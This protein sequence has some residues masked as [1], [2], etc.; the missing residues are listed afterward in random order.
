MCVC[1]I[2]LLHDGQNP[3]LKIQA[4]IKGV[5]QPLSSCDYPVLA[6]RANHHVGAV[7]GAIRWLSSVHWE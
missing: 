1:A 5:Y 7:F 4:G 6:Y 3:D 2:K